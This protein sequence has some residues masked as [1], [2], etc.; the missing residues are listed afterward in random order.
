MPSQAL[1]YS[2]LLLAIGVVSFS[3]ILIRWASEAS[4]LVIATY[5]LLVCALVLAPWALTHRLATLRALRRSDWLLALA[6][7]V[8]LGLHFVTWISSLSYTS[9]ASSVVLVTTNPIFVGLGSYFLL[10]ER[11]P[12]LLVIGIA[13]SVGGALLIGYGDFRVGGEALWGDALAL[14]G[15]VM[16]SAYFL[17]GRRLRPH[18]DLVSYIF[19][20]YSMAA[21]VLLGLALGSGQELFVYAPSTYLWMLL[22]ALGPQLLGHTT[23]NWA[24]RYL[25]AAS[26]AVVLLGEPVGSTILAYF[27]LDEEP[28]EL[29]L[30]GG[31]LI[32]MGIYLA[33]RAETVPR[34]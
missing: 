12:R 32:L 4:P 25:P 28:S 16:A 20:V 23:F 3:A 24:L 17:V 9:V 1:I 22:L 34:R 2:A 8:C 21:L 10:R 11:L 13:I 31:A 27:L 26:V 30:F 5:R 15:A 14:M 6:S 7:G 29:K 33:V 19:V 18:M